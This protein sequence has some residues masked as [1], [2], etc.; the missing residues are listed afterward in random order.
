MVNAIHI[1]NIK[2]TEYRH[3]LPIWVLILITWLRWYLSGF[4]TVKLLL[5]LHA[6][7]F[8]RKSLCPQS[9]RGRAKLHLLEEDWTCTNYLEFF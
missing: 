5:T 9:N 2:G 3:D 6:V 1:T 7:L 8:I 4:S